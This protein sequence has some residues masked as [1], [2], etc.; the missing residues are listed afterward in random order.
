MVKLDVL[1]LF[2]KNFRVCRKNLIRLRNLNENLR[3]FALYGGPL[4]EANRARKTF[5]N[6]VDDFYVYKYEKDPIW[7]W[8]NLDQMVATWFVDKGQDL[9]WKT[10][11]IMHW[12]MLILAPLQNLFFELQPGEILLSGLRPI[13]TVSS[14]W[15]LAD[16]N[17]SDLLSFKKL[18]H[19]KF[20]YEDELYACL[21]IVVCYPRQFLEQ[22]ILANHPEIGFLEY[23]IPTLANI[24][25]I[26]FCKNHVFQPWWASNPATKNVPMGERI[27]NAVSQEVP[28]TVIFKE[29]LKKD[30][31]R[32]FHPVFKNYPYCIENRHI[33]L[34]LFYFYHFIEILSN[35]LKRLKYIIQYICHKLM[36][37]RS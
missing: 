1:F 13:S 25:G 32:L 8:K 18:L 24:F 29:L 12:D 20:N 7:K 15:P 33:A 17:D 34:T 10:I 14:W 16:P 9:D 23:K 28:R 22:Y 11:L 2:H 3:V 27:L 21:F 36:G 4:S 5:Q 26:P 6:L 37:N 19:N 35:L 31:H 30:G